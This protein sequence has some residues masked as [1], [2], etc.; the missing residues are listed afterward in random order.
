MLSK[1][2]L[3]NYYK[4]ESIQE[5]I[6]KASKNKEVA[7]RYSDSFGKRPDA[8]QYS[9]EV[10]EV[11]KHGATSFHCSEELWSNPLQLNSE[12]N[13]RQ[14]DNLRIGW[15][16][17]ID[18]D[19]KYW[20]YSKLI[21]HLIIK[22]LKAHGVNSVSCKF[23][24]NKGF[25]IG[26]PFKSFPL[27]VYGKETRLL[28]PEGVKRIVN[29][30]IYCIDSKANNF[31][32][33]RLITSGKSIEMLSKEFDK[34]PEEIIKN[35]CENCGDV[36]SFPKEHVEFTCPICGKIEEGDVKFKTCD[37]CKKLMKKQVIKKEVKCSSCGM[38]N[39]KQGFDSKAIMDVD[40]LLISSRHLYRMPYSLHEKSGLA[41]VVIDPTS[42]LS[43]DKKSADPQN[44]EAKL[45]FLDDSIVSAGEAE[46]LIREAFDFMPII[47][48]EEEDKKFRYEEIQD[49]IPE[50]FFPPCIKN[51]LN[52]LK[53]GRK[54]SLFVLMNFLSC[55]GYSNERIEE[56]V[57]EWNKKNFRP[58]KLG[59]VMS[60]LKHHSLQTE[61]IP[62]PNCP[63]VPDSYYSDTGI[64]TPDNLC[65]RVKNPVNYTR[66]KTS[67][68]KKENSQKGRK[69]SD[70]E[71][72]V[73]R[74]TRE[75][76]KK[77]KE[78]VKRKLESGEIKK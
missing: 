43:F 17:V 2:V 76:R 36:V 26:V 27:K 75:E 32:L 28:F 66:R 5:A 47:Q 64:C 74:K 49:E 51:I 59:Y 68:L 73:R 8:L 1:S 58:L 6:F 21:T 34:K 65:Q 56:I 15:D 33:T 67:S 70:D 19:C 63:N 41:S 60:Q 61:R 30:L 52:G 78:E 14:L 3:L 42:V 4:R 25:H 7:T 40:T 24:G 22:A 31:E 11:A 45:M 37:K 62:P 71:K 72:E 69:L 12:M 13:S 53:D 9:N 50:Q 38:K 16:L 35:Y 48:S 54:R 39:F 55:C 23:S 57:N 77:F 18:V 29:Y 20:E 10:L 44:V 46:Q